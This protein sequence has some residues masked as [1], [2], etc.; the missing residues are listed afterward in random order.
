MVV[1]SALRPC[2]GFHPV[3]VWK[4]LSSRRICSLRNSCRYLSIVTTVGTTS[5]LHSQLILCI[6]GDHC[7]AAVYKFVKF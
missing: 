1:Y 4:G 7:I 6:H 2:H 3:R 5:L